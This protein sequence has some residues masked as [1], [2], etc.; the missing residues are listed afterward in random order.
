MNKELI[1]KPPIVAFDFDLTLAETN[2]PIIL[3]PKPYAISTIKELKEA[4]WRVIIFTNREGQHLETV[5]E[6]ANK[7]DLEFDAYNNNSALTEEE[8][9]RFNYNDSR[10]LG[11]DY[12][13]DDRSVFWE[14]SEDVLLK[15]KH[16]LL[17]IYDERE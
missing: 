4:G 7:W 9:R 11:F 5:K 8:W 13:V 3:K 12:I 15:V 6:W 1:F 14:D 10:K 17:D 16:K 2:F